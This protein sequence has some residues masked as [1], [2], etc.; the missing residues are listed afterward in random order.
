M[1]GRRPDTSQAVSPS[2]RLEALHVAHYPED[3]STYLSTY[4]GAAPFSALVSSTRETWTNRDGDGEYVERPGRARFPGP[5]DRRRW[6]AAGRPRLTAPVPVEKSSIRNSLSFA[7]ERVTYAELAA[8]PTGGRAMYEELKRAAHGAGPSP[9]EEVFVTVGDL[10]RTG[11]VPPRIRAALY[12]ALAYVKGIRLVGPVRD[13]LGR[14][15]LAVEIDGSDNARHQLIFDPD[16]SSLLAEQDVLTRRVPYLDAVA[17]T[18]I[19]ARVV[20][21]SAAV[22]APGRRP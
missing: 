2:R 5:R 15:G 17:G 7:N 8:K 19:G 12:R 21:R 22:D 9:D 14:P 3:R 18:V 13:P 11:P 16:T 20:V 10:L 4:A 6:Q 1:V